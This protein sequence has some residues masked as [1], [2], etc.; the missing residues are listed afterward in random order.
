MAFRVILFVCMIGFLCQISADKI[1]LAY[2]CHQLNGPDNDVCEKQAITG[3]TPGGTGTREKP[4]ESCPRTTVRVQP[5]EYPDEEKHHVHPA[6][7]PSLFSNVP[8]T[9]NFVL[10]DEDVDMLSPRIR[11][12]LTVYHKGNDIALELAFKVG[13]APTKDTQNWT[14]YFH[15][16][17][18][19]REVESFLNISPQQKFKFI[20]DSWTIG[21]KDRLTRNLQ[22]M[23]LIHGKKE[24]DFYPTTFV[25]PTDV[26][27]LR[28]FSHSSTE[29][30]VWIVKP[31]CYSKAAGIYM[32]RKWQDANRFRNAVVQR[33][34]VCYKHQNY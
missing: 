22:N 17:F 1:E 21:C 9:I 11:N 18:K 12:L 10:P 31:Y 32:T 29:D 4:S 6:L 15:E 16:P 2:N 8:P 27:G 5:E 3:T 30:H 24:Y 28:Q 7:T 26:N 14:M 19:P 23:A 13:F 20:P 33:Q 25:L 34:V